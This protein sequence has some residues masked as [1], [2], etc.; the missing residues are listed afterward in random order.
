MKAS[1]TT[2]FGSDRKPNIVFIM[3]DQ[4]H[5]KAISAYGNTDVNTPNLD[6]MVQDGYS[7]MKMHTIMPMCCPAR[8]SWMTGRTSKEHGLV[9]N[10]CPINPDFPDLAQ[11]FR[12]HDSDYE[13]V[14][15]GKWHVTDRLPE[16]SFDKVLIHE[17][18][19]VGELLD[20][21]VARS[22]IAYIQNR[23][24]DKPFF[25]CAS[26]M[27][28]HDCCYTAG[29]NGG[30]GKFK[31][32]DGWT[33]LPSL[34]STYAAPVSPYIYQTRGWDDYDRRYYI[35]TYYRMVE[36]VDEQ[37]GLIYDAIQSSCFA[38]NT[39][40]I[41]S[42][43]HG[44]GLLFHGNLGKG[45][46]ADEAWRVPAI[47]C[48]KGIPKNVQD[49]THLA[50]SLDIPATIC[51]YAGVPNLPQSNLSRSWR[52]IMDGENPDWREYVVGET[53]YPYKGL[54]FRDDQDM[55]TIF[56]DE[57]DGNL[58]RAEIFDMD[59]DS[60]ETTDLNDG[61][62]AAETV[63]ARHEGYILDYLSNIDTSDSIPDS[64][65]GDIRTDVDEKGWYDY[66]DWYAELE[67]ELT[68]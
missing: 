53:P 29:A 64:S 14:Y 68:S 21:A 31:L 63:I 17:G 6:R 61:S 9:L 56:Y 12:D 51:D 30:S 45:M 33:D 67:Q 32:S 59:A 62:S 19:P 60:P 50:S 7:F 35:Y 48:G 15:T 54:S 46:L 26:L 18:T 66:I 8:A 1:F 37:I 39:I 2:L 41:F 28:P 55:K 44:E 49:S 13:T 40:V 27:N 10:G 20:S 24:H 58:Y 38:D 23:G 52:L 25:M 65:W 5:H 22:V 11:W 42:S 3:V 57:D 4:M 36:M 43:D 34:P 16:E 47:I